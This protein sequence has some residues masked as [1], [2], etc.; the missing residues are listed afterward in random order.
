M[1][2]GRSF[3]LVIY[4]RVNGCIGPYFMKALKNL[5]GTALAY[6]PIVN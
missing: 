1:G 5:L 2:P 6:K 4:E 3:L